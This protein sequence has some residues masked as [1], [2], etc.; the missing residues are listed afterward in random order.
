M[1][2][3]A[4]SVP[5][6]AQLNCNPSIS[7]SV[8][9][10]TVTLT[11]NSTPVANPPTRHTYYSVNWGDNSQ[12][13][14]SSN[15][16]AI[17]HTYSGPGTY[18]IKLYQ[19]V[20]DSNGS[21][22]SSCYDS[23][24]TS[25]TITA[26]PAN[27]ISGTVFFD[28]INAGPTDSMM[29][30]LITF[31]SATNILAAVDSQRKHVYSPFYNFS[32]KA[33]GQYRTKVALMNGVTSGT[34][35]VPTYHDS[36]LTWNGAAVINH[37]GGSSINKHIYMRTGTLTSGP[38][39]VGGNVSAGA[40]KGTANGIEG[41]N[42][43]L[44][45]NAGKVVKFTITDA[46]GDYSFSN[47]ANGIYTIHPENLSFTTTT[48]SVTVSNGQASFTDINFERSLKNLT[49]KPKSAG[50]NNVN[51]SELSFVVFPNPAKN[52][53]TINWNTLTNE[54]AAINITDLSGKVVMSTEV[55]MNNNSKVD[56]SNLNTGFYFMTVAT[57]N[58]T[59]TQK[60]I[61]Q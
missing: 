16:N 55:S 49:I 46:N 15:N 32:G 43:L 19:S 40:N 17:N 52:M 27:V 42:I 47:L 53:V 54:V 22:G 11:N 38:G 41:M 60:L 56:V 51:N 23:T 59:N 4:L 3:L 30:W 61:I 37:T 48:T 10:S 2:A 39:F 29:I 34:G 6:Y 57:E 5:T 44:L 14:G 31:D 21:Q 45:D 58:G 24:S 26:P 20:I 12:N 9:G 25:V 28:S 8:S 1:F 35:N 18:T 33:A 7:A 50:I 13:T 36:S